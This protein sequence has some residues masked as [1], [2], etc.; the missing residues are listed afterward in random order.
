VSRQAV[1]WQ[2][3]GGKAVTL[4]AGAPFVET[5]VPGIYQ[6]AWGDRHRQF[7]VNLPVEESRIAP[8]PVDAL[9][10]LGVPLGPAAE[11][12]AAPAR[13]QHRE[14]P[15]AELENRQKLWRWLLAAALAITLVEIL[16]SGWLSRR[17][18]AS[19]PASIL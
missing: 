19:Q 7:A 18:P 9:A 8:M 16:L 2:T 11:P 10:R 6:A 13:T 1:Q 12:K 5:D 4:P 15:R 17:P 3:P 14:L